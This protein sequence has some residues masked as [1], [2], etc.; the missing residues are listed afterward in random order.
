MLAAN[1]NRTGYLDIHTHT[2]FEITVIDKRMRGIHHREE[3]LPH[4]P[5]DVFVFSSNEQHYVTET[6]GDWMTITQLHFEPRYLIE[7]TDEAY[8]NVFFGFCFSHASDSQ[9]RIPADKV[10]L[11]RENLSMIRQEFEKQEIGYP[12]AIRAYLNLMLMELIRQHD[13]RSGY[14]PDRQRNLPNILAVYN[15][16]DEHMDEKLTLSTLASVTGLSPNYLSHI[17]KQLNGVSLW[18]YITAKRVEKAS[19]LILFPSTHMTMLEIAL[20]CGFNNTV[21]FNKAFKKQMGFTPSDL[22][23]NPQL[24]S[25]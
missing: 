24:L 9:N 5:G 16:I 18:E 19:S 22:K 13:Y 1:I 8:R 3:K 7:N 6:A 25:Y 20:E 12:I 23:K 17:F 21:S 4:C 11:F 15:Y 2:Y 14:F 10:R